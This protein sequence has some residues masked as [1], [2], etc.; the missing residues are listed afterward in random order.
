[1]KVHRVSKLWGLVYELGNRVG[2]SWRFR[3]QLEKQVKKP[4][5][6]TCAY[7]PGPFLLPELALQGYGCGVFRACS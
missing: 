5:A 6:W 3:Y 7:K 4:G 2:E 1:M